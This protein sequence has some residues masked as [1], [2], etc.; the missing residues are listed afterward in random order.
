M[1]WKVLARD[2]MVLGDGR[3][4]VP[5]VARQTWP[6]PISGTAAGMVR[7][8]FLAASS[9]VSRD[10]ALRVL[11]HVRIRGPWVV[12]ETPEGLE[13]HFFPPSDVVRH[14]KD[15]LLQARVIRPAKQEGVL[16]PERTGALP[17]L[18]E[19]DD[20]T[21]DGEKLEA[22]KMSVWP[23]SALLRYALGLAGPGEVERGIELPRETRIH[24]AI[25]DR[26]RTAEPG[27][28][29]SSTGV[30]FGEDYALA[31]EVEVDDGS[32]LGEARGPGVLGGE[33]RPIFV[34]R[35][36]GGLP[37]LEAVRFG[38]QMLEEVVTKAAGGEGG[39]SAGGLRLQ[40]LTHACLHRP[41]FRQEDL[42]SG[43]TPGWLPSWLKPREGRLAGTHPAFLRDEMLR[44]VELELAALCMPNGY[45]P[46][47]GWNLQATSGDNASPTGAPREV[48]RLVPAG[49]I[50]YF[51][52]RRGGV[53]LT[54]RELVPLFRALWMCDL[55]PADK[56][57]PDE[58]HMRAHPAHDGFGLALPGLWRWHG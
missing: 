8:S 26:A 20:T 28:L 6:L 14:P 43:D 15:G 32:G 2:P 41:A 46:I 50:Y 36:P 31:L 4:G 45:I 55:E 58:A 34:A 7:S 37:V 49:S 18:L 27:Q 48:R 53:L 1:L 54:G 44:D 57:G 5:F 12:R 3:G 39:Q 22:L 11:R 16:W 51:T 47:S 38:D 52:A 23:L 9:Q 21:G 40:L 56:A 10:Q 29:Y 17:G 25:H 30:R 42:E 24:V 13:H 35:Q 33:A 19:L